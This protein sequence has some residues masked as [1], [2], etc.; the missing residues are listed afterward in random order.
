MKT[1]IAAGFTFLF[2]IAASATVYCI[3]RYAGCDTDIATQISQCATFATLGFMVRE[4]IS[5]VFD[6]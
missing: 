4:S 5:F 2:T 1:T 3:A 6:K